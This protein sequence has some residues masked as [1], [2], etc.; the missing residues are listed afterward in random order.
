MFPSGVIPTA[1]DIL[2]KHDVPK[3][4]DYAAD[5]TVK[6]RHLG[7][8]HTNRGASGEVRLTLPLAKEND[9]FQFRVEQGQYL[10]IAPYSGG[11]LLALTAAAGQELRSQTIGASLALRGRADGNWEVVRVVGVWEEI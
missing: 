9:A 5:T 2:A 1:E 8:I 4:I 6:T 11:Q 3:E 10:R 7:F